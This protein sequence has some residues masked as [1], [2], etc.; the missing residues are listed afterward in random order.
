M[1]EAL[2][3]AEKS[4]WLVLAARSVQASVAVGLALDLLSW[5]WGYLQGAIFSAGIILPPARDCF[6]QPFT[7]Q[8]SDMRGCG[9]AD[10]VFAA[11]Q[12]GELIRPFIS[13]N[14][15]V[16]SNRSA[17]CGRWCLG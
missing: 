10:G 4:P 13:Q 6:G 11:S 15:H 3:V 12:L 2:A 17:A 5:R 7:G 16:P 9:H 1:V 8:P 14:S